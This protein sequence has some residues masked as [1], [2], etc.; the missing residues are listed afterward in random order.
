MKKP[1]GVSRRDFVSTIALTGAGLTIVPRHVLG[2]G[3]QAP[4]DTVNVA[5]VGVGGMGGSNAQALFGHQNLVAFCD[6][7]DAYME[8]K[9][10]S[11]RTAAAAPPAAAQQGGGRQGGTPPPAPAWKDYGASK[12]QTEANA[13]WAMDALPARR[14]KFLD[15]QL[16]KLK[17]YRD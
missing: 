11:W 2:R 10:Q 4:S 8:T 9:I 5:I 15:Q 6:V 1:E 17:K 16:P 14:Q 7:D 13:K 3:F 12:A